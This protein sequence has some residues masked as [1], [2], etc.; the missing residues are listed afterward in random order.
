LDSHDD[1]FLRGGVR[2]ASPFLGL[3]DLGDPAQQLI[4]HLLEAGAPRR[5]AF[6]RR[7]RAEIAERRI[8]SLHLATA[9]ARLQLRRLRH[10]LQPAAQGV[11]ALAVL[12]LEP[13]ALLLGFLPAL[14]DPLLRGGEATIE[15]LHLR[16]GVLD[17]L[18]RRPAALGCLP[19]LRRRQRG[20][21]ARQCLDLADDAFELYPLCLGSEPAAVAFRAAIAGLCEPPRERGTRVA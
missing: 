14:E 10:L 9:R 5:A 20:G 6:R 19:G 16:A 21:V 17:R 2:P 12:M 7:K 18:P 1:L 8:G 4:T 15:G 11:Q 13:G 3:L